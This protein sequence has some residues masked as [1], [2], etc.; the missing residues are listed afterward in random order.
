MTP[1]AH[2]PTTP[3]GTVS[4]TGITRQA[5]SFVCHVMSITRGIV[6]RAWSLVVAG[7]IFDQ[8]PDACHVL[9]D[10]SSLHDGPRPC[11]SAAQQ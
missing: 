4:S 2:P 5:S 10:Y 6:T 9:E 8:A 7:D 11:S 1:S 3:R